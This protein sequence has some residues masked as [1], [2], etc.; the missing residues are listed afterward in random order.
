MG[1]VR[2]LSMIWSG[3][4]AV[5]VE[6]NSGKAQRPQLT[7]FSDSCNFIALEFCLVASNLCTHNIC[8]YVHTLVSCVVYVYVLL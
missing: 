3:G 1:I 2:S 7:V 4:G 6:G 5:C 8:T